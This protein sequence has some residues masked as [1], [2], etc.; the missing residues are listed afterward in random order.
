MPVDLNFSNE[1]LT[2]RISGEID[3]HAAAEMRMAIDGEIDRTVPAVL[4]LDLG[5][6]SFMDSSGI[7]LILGRAR[8]QS[9]RGGSAV[10]TNPNAQIRK[11][12]KLSGLTGMIEKE[13]R[14]AENK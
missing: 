3:H 1:R 9:L 10:I 8:T 6:V 2:A 5:G 14:N 4:E 11:I 7:G 13:Q 12:L